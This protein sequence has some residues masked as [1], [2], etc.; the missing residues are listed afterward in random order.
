MR[1][2]L[3]E[4]RMTSP[5]ATNLDRNPGYVGRK[6]WAKPFNSFRFGSHQATL[7]QTPYLAESKLVLWQPKNVNHLQLRCAQGTP[8]STHSATD[9][10]GGERDQVET[11][12]HP[13]AHHSHA[14]LQSF[15]HL[16]QR[17]R[18]SL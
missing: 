14:A 4:S 7:P 11:S 13:G 5:N 16:L 12:S 17:V 3:K 8:V 9:P 15:L 18:Q 10:D 6:R 2:S 1:L